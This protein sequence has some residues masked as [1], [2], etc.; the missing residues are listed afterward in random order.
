MKKL[1]LGNGYFASIGLI[2]LPLDFS[3]F[4]KVRAEYLS[5]VI[6]Q[7]AWRQNRPESCYAT[8]AWNSHCLIINI[9][10]VKI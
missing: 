5:S 10:M 1:L 8:K 9:L 4:I 6:V 7:W 3:S 2:I